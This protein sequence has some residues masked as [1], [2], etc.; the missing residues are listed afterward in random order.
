MK[1]CRT[2]YQVNKKVYSVVN[3]TVCNPCNNST[4]T[5]KL[6]D[7]TTLIDLMLRDSENAR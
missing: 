2:V 4:K 3:K 7:I 6:V 5:K 1:L